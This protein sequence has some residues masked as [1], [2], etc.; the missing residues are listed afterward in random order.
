MSG[1]LVDREEWRLATAQLTDRIAELEGQV[2]WWIKT[3][4]IKGDQYKALLNL[5]EV[6]R[7]ALAGL[8][9]GL[10]PASIEHYVNRVVPLDEVN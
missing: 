3:C 1:E 9:V 5:L 4:I 8:S 10:D 7:V 2:R 6:Q